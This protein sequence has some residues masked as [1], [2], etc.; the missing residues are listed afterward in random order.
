MSVRQYGS[1]HVAGFAAALS[2][3]IAAGPAAVA[4]SG[5]SPSLLA[6]AQ[7][8]PRAFSIARQPLDSALTAFSAETRIQVLVPGELTRGITSP[9][10]SGTHSPD[11]ALQQILAGTGLAHRFVNANTVT[12]ERVTTGTLNVPAASVEAARISDPGMTEGSGSYAGSKVT[13]GSK[14]PT[15][16]RE[17]PQ[18]V[19]VVTRQRIEDQNFSSI[20][21]AMKY[22]TGTTVVP[23]RNGDA[24][25]F[26]FRGYFPDAIQ[27]DGVTRASDANFSDAFDLAVYD[28]IEVLRG[29]A[30]LFQGS[31]EPGGSINL[32]RK[33]PTDMFRVGGAVQYGSWDNVRGEADV[34]GRLVESGKLRGR[35]V[36]AFQ[37]RDS[38]RDVAESQ[39]GL[40]YGSM[41]ADLGEATTLFFGGTWQDFQS[42]ADQGLPAYSNGRPWNGSRSVFAGADWNRRDTQLAD[43][44]VKLQHEFDTGAKIEGS[45]VYLMRSIDEKMAYAN[46]TINLS[47]GEVTLRREKSELSKNEYSTDVN[48]S[49]PFDIGGLKQTIVVGADYRKFFENDKVG[50]GANAPF[51][52]FAPNYAI[53]EPD[54]PLTLSDDEIATEQYGTYGQARIKPLSWA[55]IVI[56]G[57]MSWYDTQ[58]TNMFTDT[59][60]ASASA[61]RELTPYYGLIFDITEDLSVY[62]SYADI[63]QP[64]ARRAFGGGL[65]P[66]R[67]GNQYEVGIKGEFL[68]DKVN[69]HIAA[70][71]I[72]DQN[73]SISDPANSGFFLAAGE[74]ESKGI[75]S[76][77]G[78]ELM[79]GWNLIAGYAY[80]Y[81]EFLEDPTSKGL[82]FDPTIPKHSAAIW[83]KY[84]IQSGD[85]KGM[86]FGAGGR[87]VSDFYARGTGNNRIGQSGYA[88]ADAQI[89]YQISERIGTTFTVTNIFDEEYF[90]KLAEVRQGHF[91]EPRAFMLAVRANW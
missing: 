59:V 84:T 88:V 14:I 45:A 17:V 65:I 20:E 61:E 85:L 4:Q 46:S 63:F 18:S 62:G 36:T 30:G 49:L 78:G 43:T 48:G 50:R 52:I 25:R 40:L 26:M 51:N 74:V 60:S 12:V 53:T 47:T 7:A 34:T 2:L 21:Q 90:Q 91:G 22:T 38:F 75:E 67:V 10:I 81:A 79:P 8:G 68:N 55:T 83:S 71:R 3:A 82:T 76:E 41:E 27:T 80:N 24:D 37:D 33:R 39:K 11:A 89:G 54:I 56:G 23:F 31:G 5:P 32:V 57:R 16:I 42:S 35:F 29:P 15:S 66:P 58:T 13:V 6:Q 1:I 69:A 19:S 73:R 64:Q 87:A 86:S 77:I 44:F 28:R 70:F 72:R 9:G